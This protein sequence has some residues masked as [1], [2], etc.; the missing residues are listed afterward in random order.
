[1]VCVRP[2]S[3]LVPG[4]CNASL[5]DGRFERRQLGRFRVEALDEAEALPVVGLGEPEAS[6]VASTGA[7]EP[8]GGES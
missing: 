3:T 5:A 4:E 2:V 7:F 6:P 1:M 8:A